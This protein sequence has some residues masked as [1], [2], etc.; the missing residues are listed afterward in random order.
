MQDLFIKIFRHTT[1]SRVSA[2]KGHISDIN[3]S[4]GVIAVL[5]PT[6]AAQKYT[7]LKNKLK[8]YTKKYCQIVTVIHAK[9][10]IIHDKVNTPNYPK[11]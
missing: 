9:V 1:P 6:I 2:A 4:P 8:C 3:C 7:L 5:L 11:T 10:K